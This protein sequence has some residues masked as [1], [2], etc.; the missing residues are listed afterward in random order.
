MVDN[1]PEPMDEEV[2]MVEHYSK[3]S[4]DSAAR[5]RHSLVRS[6]GNSSCGEDRS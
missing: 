1:E 2:V 3:R 6:D 5:L 4:R